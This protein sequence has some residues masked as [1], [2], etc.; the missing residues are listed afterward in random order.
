[1]LP[2]VID[3]DMGLGDWLAVLFLLKR[4]EVDVRAII[5]MG[6]ALNVKGNVN[7]VANHIAMSA[8]ADRFRYI[9]PETVFRQGRLN[10]LL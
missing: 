1:M 6:G 3:T 9:F 5:V 2:V 4:S 8:D 10:A 7:T